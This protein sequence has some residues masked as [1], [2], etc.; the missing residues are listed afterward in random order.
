MAFSGNVSIS[1]FNAMKVIENSFRRCRLPAQSI[2]SEMQEYA[3]QALYLLLSDLGNQRTPS[4]CIE[5]VMLPM[6]QNQ[7]LVGLPVGTV[8]VLNLNYRVL[9]LLTPDS[10]T[11]LAQSHMAYFQDTTTVSTVGIKWAAAAVPLTFE[12]SDD[13]VAW[14]PVGS[15]D[16]VAATGEITWVDID[17]A[18]PHQYFR[19]TSTADILHYSITLGN[20]PQEIPLGQLNRDTYVAQ[21]NK[22]FPGR[23]NSYW[24][25][26]D[27]PRPALHIWPAPFSAAE[28]AQLIVWR[29]R[30]IMDTDNMRQDVEV[31]QRWLEAIISRLAAKM[32]AETP[33][34]DINL[35]LP[36]DQKAMAAEQR[37]WEGDNDGSPTFINPGI[38]CYTR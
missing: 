24:Y 13:G 33:S 5:R 23:P 29:H 7:P 38:G 15:Q 9:Q 14:T 31:P 22:V 35:I 2:T 17:A 21:S 3:R 30:H 27:L 4:W 34:V 1:T 36:L 25:Q 16:T 20:M 37:A 18:L 8:D 11:D 12:V 10:V 26:R 32:A 19:I 6:Y 28:Q